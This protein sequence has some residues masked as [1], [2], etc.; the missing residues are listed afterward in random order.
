[1]AE[2]HQGRDFPRGRMPTTEEFHA[3]ALEAWERIPQD[4]RD[5]CGNVV[6]RVV[7]F[8]D[9]DVMREMELDSSY[10]ILGLFE[11]VGLAH[12]GELPTGTMPNIVTLYRKPIVAYWQDYEETLED[13]VAH[14][15]IHE[16]GHHFGL[17]DDDMYG[18]E[19]EAAREEGA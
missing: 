15:L 6:I 5:M 3:M 7:D 9:D 8:P 19:D 11:G 1:M 16:I 17:S 4:F 14:V 10:D 13:L 18:L 12:A 2:I